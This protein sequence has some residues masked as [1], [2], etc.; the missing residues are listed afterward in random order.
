VHLNGCL[1]LLTCGGARV[2]GP[3]HVTGSAPSRRT[4][5]RLARPPVRA[6]FAYDWLG[7][8]SRPARHPSPAALRQLG[9]FRRWHGCAFG[10]EWHFAVGFE[11]AGFRIRAIP[12][13]PRFPVS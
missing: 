2:A 12:P 10:L 5:L 11:Q 6:P 4:P 9:M 13:C 3:L 1:L 7:P 8:A